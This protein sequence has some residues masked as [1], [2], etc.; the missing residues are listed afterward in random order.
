[1]HNISTEKSLK[2]LIVVLIAIT[3]CTSIFFFVETKTE[4]MLFIFSIIIGIIL[5]RNSFL[6]DSQRRNIF[7]L[8]EKSEIVHTRLEE[9]DNL[10]TEF[11]SLATH[12]LRSPLAKIQ[13]Y[14]SMILEE[15]FCK[16][17]AELKEP[18]QRI[19][20][21]SQNLGSLLNDFLDVAQIE[22]GES[23]YNLKSTNLV[24]I[25]NKVESSF[26]DVFDNTGLKFT[27]TYNQNEE[28]KI[29]ADS[30]K[31][32][33][34]IS[35]L[36]DNAVRYTPQGEITISLAEKGDDVIVI[37]KDT[38][39]GIE[40]SEIDQLFEKFRRGKNAYNTS[41]SGSG[42]GLYVAREIIESQEGRIWL[43]SDGPGK[44]STAFVAFPLLKN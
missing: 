24:D 25:L 42:L 20:L 19:F 3:I 27:T 4:E 43:K 30:Q 17:P 28:I 12:Q 11:V 10:K 29:L 37:I 14:S 36:L 39:V 21:S 2:T 26:K 40:Q 35:K 5:I 1:M 32:I 15:E 44:G 6:E 31:T 9:L 23:F 8:V 38:G 41:V 22:K 16:L 13:G 18:L 33:S 34:A 7:S